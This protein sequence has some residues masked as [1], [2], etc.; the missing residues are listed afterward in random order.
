M[1]TLVREPG[2]AYVC[3]TGTAPLREVAERAK[4]MD[5]DYINEAGNFVSDAFLDYAQPLVGKL[6]AYV[7]LQ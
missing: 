3:T 1:V 7:R 5:D 4:P 6:P 2:S